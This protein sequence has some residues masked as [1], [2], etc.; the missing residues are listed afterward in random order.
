[1]CHFSAKSLLMLLTTE[2]NFRKK[3]EHTFGRK[4]FLLEF[5][6]TMPLSDYTIPCLWA[7]TMPTESLPAIWKN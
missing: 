7:A 6:L 1:M 5:M 4:S 2:S 3:I